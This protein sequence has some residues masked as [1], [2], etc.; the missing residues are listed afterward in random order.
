MLSSN[1]LVTRFTISPDPRVNRMINAIY[2]ITIPKRVSVKAMRLAI[3]GLK[4][5]FNLED[6]IS[7][8]PS[9]SLI[10]LR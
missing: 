5:H 4:K 7:I 6:L 9:V 1:L 10:L 3:V 2:P 8:F